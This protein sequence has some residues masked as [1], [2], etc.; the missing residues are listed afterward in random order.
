[1][2]EPNL[3]ETWFQYL[4]SIPTTDVGQFQQAVQR[5]MEGKMPT[6]T[7]VSAFN[8]TIHQAT[9]GKEAFA[10]REEWLKTMGMVPRERY[11]ALLEKY[12][13]ALQ[14]LEAAEKQIESLNAMLS[15]EMQKEQAKAIETWQ[16]SFEQ[17]LKTQ[18]DW[19][20]QFA[21]VPD[22]SKKEDI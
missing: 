8:Q 17:G 18:M 20:K 21:A 11:L 6:F 15:G 9:Q 12:E 22:P 16:K 14:Q 10:V 2:S 5:F 1:M 19:W 3:L 7:D 4:A 13:V